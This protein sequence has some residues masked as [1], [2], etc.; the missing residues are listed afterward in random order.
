MNVESTLGNLQIIDTRLP[1]SNPY[2]WVCNLKQESNTSFVQLRFRSHQ[3]L[4]DF[5]ALL[6]NPQLKEKLRKDTFRDSKT[7][8]TL[9]FKERVPKDVEFHSVS[10]QLTQVNLTYVNRFVH[11]LTSYLTDM[12]KLEA[13]AN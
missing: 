8:E 10:V 1:E 3:P 13:P 2:R 11:E 9:Q 7:L 12:F 6:E 4:K 5:H